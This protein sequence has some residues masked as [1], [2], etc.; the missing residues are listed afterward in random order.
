MIETR[1]SKANSHP[2]LD[3][4]QPAQ[5]PARSLDPTSLQSHS[6]SLKGLSTH[7]PAWNV[8]RK[9]RLPL[10]RS[11]YPPR[12]Q[13][14]SDIPNQLRPPQVAS[15]HPS[16]PR[17]CLSAV[18]NSPSISLKTTNSCQQSLCTPASYLRPCHICYRRPT[19]RALIEAYAD[20]S[21]CG[22]RS[23][24]IC[25]RQCDGIDYTGSSHLPRETCLLRDP[26]NDVH[27]DTHS[28]TPT[29]N[30][31]RKICS[32]CA[33][34]NVT[35]SGIEVVRCLDCLRGHPFH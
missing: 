7:H 14:L 1:I 6:E 27:E 16:M 17:I 18:S 32:R 28:Q 19:T 13:P 35:E 30:H 31:P 11:C 15:I 25:L 20:C 29:F 2:I 23:C 8:P 12:T 33:V 22:Q 10:H 21:I 4:D 24:Y 5:L 3:S 26:S 34:E 9:R